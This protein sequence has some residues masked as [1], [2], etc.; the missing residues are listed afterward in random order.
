M[1]NEHN[2][3]SLFDL[4]QEPNKAKK[5]NVRDTS[6]AHYIEKIKNGEEKRQAQL[7]IQALK[8]LGQASHRMIAEFLGYLPS[9]MTGCKATLKKLGIIYE[10]EKLPCKAR[11]RQ[12]GKVRNVW[13]LKLREGQQ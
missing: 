12:D 2:Q 1:D 11:L 6:I 9:N 8:E 3:G 7:Y 10:T 4:K 5:T 13:Y